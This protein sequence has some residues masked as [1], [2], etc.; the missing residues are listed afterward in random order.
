MKRFAETALAA[1]GSRG[2]GVWFAA[3]LGLVAGCGFGGGSAE[4][5][6]GVDGRA[7]DAAAGDAG[8]ADGGGAIRPVR[9]RIEVVELADPYASRGHAHGGFLA[10]A[11]RYLHFVFYGN[12]VVAHWQQETL[13]S[14]DC[15]LLELVPAYCSDCTGLCVADEVCEPMPEMVS[16]GE[17][18]FSGLTVPLTLEPGTYTNWYVSQSSVP[19]DAFSDDATVTVTA[20]GDTLPG[21]SLSAS[22]VPP[23]VAAI[24]DDQ[25]EIFD[26]A[27]YTLDWTPAAAGSRVRL[28]LNANNFGHGLPYEAIIECDADDAQGAIT[29]PRELIAEFPAT[30]RWEGCAGSDCPVSRLTRYREDSTSVADG[31]I[32]FWVGSEVQFW[33]VHDTQ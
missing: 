9:G 33:V 29:V 17:L 7:V 26:D 28:T 6:G 5:G 20:S 16:V 3:L 31:D 4:D 23:L 1:G 13:R 22:A 30:A 10:T 8:D 24:E 15:R 25:I 21:F 2:K 18:S 27:D 12:V 11:S 19:A 32:V 14:G